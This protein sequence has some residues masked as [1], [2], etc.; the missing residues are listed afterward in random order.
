MAFTSIPDSLIQVGKAITRTLWK[1]YVKDNLD[2]LNT[3]AAALEASVN[4]II[5]FDEIVLNAA[6]L[7][8]GGTITGLDIYRVPNDFSLTDAK[9]FIFEKGALT[10]NLEMDIQKSTT[11]D[12]TT[13]IS[14]FTT[15]PKIDYSTASDFDESSNTVFN[16]TNQQVVE[17]DYLKF[18]IT[19]LPS[20]GPIGKFG[21]FLVGEPS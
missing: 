13:S 20:S 17:G 2:D 21:I 7:K 18:N 6:G 3:R 8:D 16:S 15:K 4:K 12:F 11:P 14:V 5:I 9:L 19:E 1:T 10:G